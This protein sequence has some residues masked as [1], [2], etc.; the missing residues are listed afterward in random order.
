MKKR[1]NE[2]VTRY[3]TKHHD[4]EEKL[5]HF[6]VFIEDFFQ[7]MDEEYEDIKEAF[8]DELEEFT[9]E[10]DE[11]KL[12]A[13]VLNLKKKDGAHSGMKWSPEEVDSVAKQYEVESKI[14]AHGKHYDLH[15]FW[16]AMNYV[17]AV[18]CNVNRTVN[19][20]VDLAVDEYVNKN[21]CLDDLV[22][23]VFKKI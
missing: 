6:A 1:I 2:Y 18:H 8:Y 23:R 5:N 13:I 11:E 4:N 21:I 15:K 3:I 16:F 7:H 22:K 20:Y 14:V 17:Y 12:R 10:V 19:G 9:D